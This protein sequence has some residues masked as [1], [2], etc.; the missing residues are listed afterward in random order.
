[1]NFTDNIKNLFGVDIEAEQL[2]EET[3][4][5][6]RKE[7]YETLVEIKTF[8]DSKAGKLLLKI[9][10]DEEEAI[11]TQL[12]GVSHE[13]LL[14][15]QANLKALKMFNNTLEGIGSDIKSFEQLI[16]TLSKE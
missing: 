15:V 5:F 7:E 2:K 4:L 8:F 12:E 6:E 13:D 14:K 10:L 16:F 1:M 9:L 11:R 3:I